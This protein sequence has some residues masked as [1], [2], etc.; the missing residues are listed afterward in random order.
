LLPRRNP[1]SSGITELPAEPAAQPQR[2]PKREL[3]TP[4]W[5]SGF[6]QDAQPAQP[7]RPAQPAPAKAASDT[8]AFFA[9][10]AQAAKPAA[11]SVEPAGPADDDVI[12][13]RMLSEMMG[14][15]HELANSPDLDW[16]SVWD[17]GWSL[18][19]DAADKPVQ[20]HTEHG[21]PVRAPGAR[22][23]PG[24]AVPDS[25]GSG[26][27]VAANGVRDPAAV[28]A[29]IG[30]HFGGVRTGRSHAGEISQE[31]DQQ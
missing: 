31:P 17:R 18:A 13:Q 1:G 5:E 4:W 2:A 15:P 19:A 28:R 30:S 9:S 25:E 27:P 21:L 16:N 8:S 22:L 26:Q 20:S 29:S 11:P 14:D 23:V 6:Q 7:P 3:A 12:Y 10:R 24:A